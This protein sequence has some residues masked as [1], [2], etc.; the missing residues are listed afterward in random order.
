MRRV[1]E[2]C[3]GCHFREGSVCK[4][5]LTEKCV[6]NFDPLTVYRGCK[7][8][9]EWK[10]QQCGD[11]QKLVSVNQEFRRYFVRN[12][13]DRC[14]GPQIAMTAARTLRVDTVS[15]VQFAADDA[16]VS[17]A[18]KRFALP[19]TSEGCVLPAAVSARQTVNLEKAPLSVLKSRELLNLSRQDLG[20]Q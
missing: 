7:A 2:R 12:N 17:L 16:Y 3:L 10:A 19:G 14:V 1:R 6:T 5:G 4:D 8:W 20:I 11:K 13:Q 9:G 18:A 15:T